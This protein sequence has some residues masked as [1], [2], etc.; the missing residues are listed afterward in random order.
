MPTNGNGLV[1][2]VAAGLAVAAIVGGVGIAVAQ[3]RL[4]ERIKQNRAELD[5][6]EQAVSAVP[7]IKNDI[8]HIKKNMES[9]HKAILSAIRDLKQTH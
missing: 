4:E 3:G 9:E 5:R 8:K 1:S 2:K 7:L 6:R